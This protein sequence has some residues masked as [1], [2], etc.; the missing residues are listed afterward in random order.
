M[1][2]EANPGGSPVV[3]V[4]YSREDA[5]WRRK[6]VVML[7]PDVRE[8]RLEVWSDDC[9]VVGKQW[10]PQLRDAIGRSRAALLLISPDFLASEFVMEQ[11]LPALIK[12]GATLVCALVEHCR[13][14]SV[15]LL[16]AVH[17]A[18]DPERDGPLAEQTNCNGSIVRICNRLLEALGADER[19]ASLQAPD[20]GRSGGRLASTITALATT[21]KLGSLV[22]VPLLPGGFVERDELAGVR[23]SLLAAGRGAVGVTGRGLG[24]HGQGGIGKTV[25]AAALVHSDEVRAYFPDGV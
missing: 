9:N 14:Q 8:R 7:A 18:H 17:W 11:E 4:S 13:W 21:D 2:G 6:F 23:D 16:E 10:R 25:L 12:Q 19:A 3:F 5:K 22:D 24:L 20:G 1:A 15:P